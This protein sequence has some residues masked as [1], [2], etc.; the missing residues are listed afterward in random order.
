MNK[1]EFVEQAT[2]FYIQ[3][4][5]LPATTYDAAEVE[6]QVDEQ[7]KRAVDRAYRLAEALGGWPED[8]PAP[9]AFPKL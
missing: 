6:K 4:H 1:R 2:L 3:F 9:I 8:R 5:L 7:Q